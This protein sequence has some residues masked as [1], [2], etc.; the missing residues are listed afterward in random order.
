M[1]ELRGILVSH[2]DEVGDSNYGMGA[3]RWQLHSYNTAGMGEPWNYMLTITYFLRE[4][5]NCPPFL[6]ENH[7]VNKRYKNDAGNKRYNPKF[8][9]ETENF[10]AI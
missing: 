4:D 5:N 9:V 6:D 10:V 8:L 3:A 7:P 1:K 2:H